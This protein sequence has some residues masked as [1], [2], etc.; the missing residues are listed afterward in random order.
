[1]LAGSREVQEIAMIHRSYF[2]DNIKYYLFKSFS[3]D[4]VDGLN[5]FL[6][7][8]D[9]ENPPIPDKWHMDGRMLSYVL[10]TT[11]HETAATM[12]PIK[13]YGGESYLKGK[14]YY[15]WYG[16]GYVQLTWEENYKKQDDKLE[17]KGKLM[18]NPDLALDPDI[19]KKVI[20]FGMAD[21]DFTGKGLGEFFTIDKTDWYN[22]RTIV[23]GH[24]RADDIADYAEK[25]ANA[26]T[27]M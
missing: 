5:V 14:P 20:L 18:A 1:M 22:A 17:L 12:Q 16:R 4:Q 6:D 10:A 25:F 9:N 23:N 21:G 13:E 24:D 3:Q 15:P 2:F 26:L 19:A 11:Y 7:W 8:Y 27:E